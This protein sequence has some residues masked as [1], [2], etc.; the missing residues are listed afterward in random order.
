MNVNDTL[1]KKNFFELFSLPESFNID[2]KLLREN[3]RSLQ[4]RFHPDQYS[5]VSESEKLAAVQMSSLLNDAFTVLSSPVKR[6]NY[7][8]Q[9]SGINLRE[10][11]QIDSSILI[12]QI[13]FREHLEE[14]KARENDKKENELLLFKQEIKKL[15]DE[16]CLD[17]S[18][19]HE[20][21][22][23]S[24]VGLNKMKQVLSKML[25]L[26]KLLTEIELALEEFD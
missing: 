5:S 14:L 2:V 21:K 10:D 4:S 8:L 16:T 23:T 25:F 12:E 20:N 15:F 19:C 18:Q 17:F 13:A 9:L 1:H 26:D 7:I 3:Y 24:S 22:D 11:R 6:A